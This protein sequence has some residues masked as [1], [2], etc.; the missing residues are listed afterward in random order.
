MNAIGFHSLSE[1]KRRDNRAGNC[2]IAYQRRLVR[3]A[4]KKG[5]P[6][7][8]PEAQKKSGNEARFDSTFIVHWLALS[9]Y[10]A[11]L[12]GVIGFPFGQMRR[13]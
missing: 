12:K 8:N 4:E 2:G 13:V 9:G 11:C 7:A 5:I 1:C 3:L 10:A 6:Q